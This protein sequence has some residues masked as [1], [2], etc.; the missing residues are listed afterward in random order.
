MRFPD[1]QVCPIDH[2]DF[3]LAAFGENQNHLPEAA[4]INIRAG[5]KKIIVVVNFKNKSKIPL[6]GRSQNENWNAFVIPIEI[7]FNTVVGFGC[8]IFWYPKCINE[9]DVQEIPTKIRRI[10]SRS[11]RP[12]QDKLLLSFNDK[13]AQSVLV[14]GGKGASLA[15]LRIIQEPH[16]RAEFLDKRDRSNQ[17]LSALVDQ[18]STNPLKR[19]LQVQNLLSEGVHRRCRTRAGS[20]AAAIFPDPHDF[21]VPEFIVP[22][23]FVISTSALQ[24]HLDNNPKIFPLLKNLEDVVYERVKGDVQEAC[25]M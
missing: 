16:S 2:T 21:D 11:D 19:S 17:I 5:N 23:G 13:E 4:T 10:F 12:S 24:I 6:F 15:I 25:K 7:K 9:F 20:L 3:H 8:A 22:Q 14:A 1:S 18:A